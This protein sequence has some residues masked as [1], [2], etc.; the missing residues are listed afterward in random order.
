MGL[1]VAS[2]FVSMAADAAMVMSRPMTISRPSTPVVRPSMSAT[3]S[4]NN[5]MMNAA[6]LMSIL[7]SQNAYDVSTQSSEVEALVERC[8]SLD[9]PETDPHCVELATAI[10]NGD[11]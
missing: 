1:V 5:T 10:Q 7:N 3:H 11:E 8:K 2:M 4:I 6:I 9:S